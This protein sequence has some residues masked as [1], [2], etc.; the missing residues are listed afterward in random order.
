MV[1]SE[2]LPGMLRHPRIFDEKT[3]LVLTLRHA[4]HRVKDAWLSDGES[5]QSLRPY[6]LSMASLAPLDSL[7]TLLLGERETTSFY[8]TSAPR[9][10]YVKSSTKI[11]ER[12]FM[13]WWAFDWRV[14][15]DK[16]LGKNKNDSIQ[17]YTSLAPWNREA[18]DMRDFN[19]F[20]KFWGWNL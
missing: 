13:S 1:Y 19:T 15:E 10:G 4:T 2:N 8:E 11:W 16:K 12:L 18:S 3:R 5:L 14:G 20:L 7:E 9:K 17:F 6:N